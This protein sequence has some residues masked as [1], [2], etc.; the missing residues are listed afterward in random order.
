MTEVDTVL[1]PTP[2]TGVAVPHGNGDLRAL[3]R[4]ARQH[5]DGL[6]TGRLE[7]PQLRAD[8]RVHELA[9]VARA[10][11]S[12]A[13]CSIRATNPNADWTLSRIAYWYPNR[14]S[15]NET[16]LAEFIVGVDGKIGDT[17]WT[18]EAYTS[19]GETVLLTDMKNFVW[20]DRYAESRAAAELRH[21]R[22][23]HGAGRE[24]HEYPRLHLHVG[25][26]AV[27][28]VDSRR[29]RRGACTTTTS[30]SRMTASK[31]SPRA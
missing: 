21:R 10:R 14:A 30:R 15:S 13:R 19:Y 29:P 27:R 17:D 16:K 1:F 22:R 8:G 20:L 25:S 18:W 5:A 31:P 6:S 3:G 23:L 12:S 26:A 28:A 24:Q 4:R 11:R 7:R 2:L 9:S